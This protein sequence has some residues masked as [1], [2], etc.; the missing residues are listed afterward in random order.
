[1]KKILG[2]LFFIVIII[3]VAYLLF[4]RISENSETD[5]T[6]VLNPFGGNISDETRTIR[7]PLTTGGS[8]SVPDFR[9]GKETITENG[10]TFYVLTTDDAVPGASNAPYSILYGTDGSITISLLESPLQE[11]RK[12]AEEALK[13]FF[14]LSNNTLCSLDVLVGVPYNVNTSYAGSNLGLSFCPGSVQL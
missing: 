7:I 5:T 8:A 12:D 2:V 1:M 6:S 10:Q 14:P 9:D 3:T 11:T 4:S 13:T